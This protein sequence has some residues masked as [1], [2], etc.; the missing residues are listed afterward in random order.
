MELESIARDGY[1]GNL[2]RTELSF[3]R[4]GDSDAEKIEEIVERHARVWFIGFKTKSRLGNSE[5][6]LSKTNAI[7]TTYV[8]YSLFHGGIHYSSISETQC[9]KSKDLIV[10]NLLPKNKCYDVLQDIL[11]E[12]NPDLSVVAKA[13]YDK[14]KA[15]LTEQRQD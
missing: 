14:I 5:K 8:G 6:N 9:K 2:T 10:T 4:V 3:T 13:C 15:G 1:W 12:L 11:D 7:C